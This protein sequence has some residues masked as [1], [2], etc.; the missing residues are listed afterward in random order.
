VSAIPISDLVAANGSIQQGDK[1]FTDFRFEPFLVAV[2]DISPLQTGAIDVQGVTAPGENG[3]RF[4]GPFS[5]DFP[6]DGGSLASATY[7]LGYDVFVTD[8][9]FKATDFSQSFTVTSGG[10]TSAHVFAT[11]KNCTDIV[12]LP[13]DGFELF[14]VDTGF[15]GAPPSSPAT[16][17]GT[18]DFLSA[19]VFLV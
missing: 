3:L 11:V 13:P 2:G 6:G 18:F 12:C 4:S 17:T 7:H 15:T 9:T 16:L 1:L 19:Q 10:V 14:G 8:P 5:A